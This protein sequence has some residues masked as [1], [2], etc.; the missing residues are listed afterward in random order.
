M[1]T[2]LNQAESIRSKS[3]STNL[4]NIAVAEMG[5]ARKLIAAVASKIRITISFQGLAP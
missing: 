2:R 4:A 1:S 3:S 5:W